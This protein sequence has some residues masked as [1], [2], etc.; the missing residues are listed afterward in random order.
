MADTHRWSGWPGAFCLDC[1]AEDQ[2][3]ICVF[4]HDEG[5]TCVEGHYMCEEGH[6]LAE[7]K[8]HQNG[9]CPARQEKP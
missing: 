1:G 6:P 5:L 9:P 3:E 7:C 8:E 2:R 4:E